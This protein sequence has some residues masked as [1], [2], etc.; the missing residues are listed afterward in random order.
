VKLDNGERAWREGRYGYGQQIRV[1]E[2]LLLVQ[3]EKGHVLLVKLSPEKLIELSR[4]NALHSKTWNPPTLAGRWLLLRND[5][6]AVC[7]ELQP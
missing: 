2:D 4:I 3:A 5:R 1:G 7:Y 6:E